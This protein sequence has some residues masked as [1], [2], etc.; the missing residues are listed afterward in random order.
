L[1]VGFDGLGIAL[2][3]QARFELAPSA[4]GLLH[5]S[6][7]EER[8]CGADNLVWSSYQHAC[9]TL[10]LP[11][12]PLAIHIDSPI[13]LSGGLG[14]SSACVVAG[15]A[16][17]YALGGLPFDR[18]AALHLATSLEG[19][20]DNVAPAILGGLVCTI[21]GDGNVWP[22]RYDVASDLRFVAIIPSYEVRTSLARRILPRE[23]PLA[24]VPWQTSRCVGM[25]Q[26]LQSGDDGLLAVCAAD[27]VHEPHRSRLIPDYGALRSASLRAGA[28][29]FFISGSGATMLAACKGE[30][31]AASVARTISMM[32][33]VSAAEGAVRGLRV[34][35]LAADAAGT[36]VECA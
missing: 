9:D 29:A 36:V 19:H 17:A 16:G 6:G 4:D 24:D 27:R 11:V 15:I 12:Q 35:V 25:V 32:E 28:A 5:V 2:G 20:P 10:G 22:L 18:D 13:P 8:F 3:M 26:A 23:V 34:E 33:S 7:C 31:A 21:T 14:S 1:G 30:R